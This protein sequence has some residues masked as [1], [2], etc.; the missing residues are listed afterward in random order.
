M[1][2]FLAYYW[3]VLIHH[4]I[5]HDPLLKH[6]D[7]PREKKIIMA[8]EKKTKAKTKEKKA[9]TEREGESGSEC[10]RLSNKMKIPIL[11]S[12]H[13]MISA[14]ICDTLCVTYIMF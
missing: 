4:E 7:F 6:D 3:Q 13:N 2:I 10:A 12:S 5:N 8:L 9:E 11:K 1:G 14:P